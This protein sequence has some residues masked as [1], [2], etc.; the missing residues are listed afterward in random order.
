MEDRSATTFSRP[1]GGGQ[2][3]LPRRPRLRLPAGSCDCHAHVFGPAALYPYSPARGY[4]PP[5]A[6]LAEYLGMHAITGIS[7]GVLVQPSVYGTDNANLLSALKTGG[8]RLRGIAVVDSSVTDE[9][10]ERLRRAG[11]RGIRFNV[12]FAGGTPLAEAARLARRVAPLGWHVQLLIDVS[13]HPHLDREFAD[14]PTPIVIDH[15]GHVPAPAGLEVAGFQALLRL[16]DGGRCWV[17]LSGPYRT[18][19]GDVPYDDVLP[20][21]R[22]LVE[23][24]PDRLVWGTDWPHPAIPGHSPNA[25][26]LVDLLETWIPDAALRRRILVE[27]PADLYGFPAPRGD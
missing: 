3:R 18:S 1:F 16:L 8:D 5:D 20:F 13:H 23:R 21:A 4:T 2:D 27:N 14:F 11:V 10:L 9:D 15:M 19:A 12:V 17:K 25:A 24:R 7:R 6:L 26:D 22:A